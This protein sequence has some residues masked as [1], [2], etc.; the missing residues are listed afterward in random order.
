[1]A[2]EIKTTEVTPESTFIPPRAA[3]NTASIP[4]NIPREAPPAAREG[5]F[6]TDGDEDILGHDGGTKPETK[7]VV[8]TEDKPSKQEDNKLEVKSATA[9]PKQE[10]KVE[11]ESALSILNKTKQPII[12]PNKPA[13]TSARDYTGFTAEEQETLK[14]MSNKAFDY[15]APILRKAKEVVAP[16]AAKQADS[17]AMFFQHPQGY[18]LHPEF[19]KSQQ[20]YTNA[21][22]EAAV[23]QEQLINIKEGK[24][25]TPPTGYDAQGN[26]IYGSKRAA[27]AQDE[28]NVQQSMN[29][30]MG[31]AQQAQLQLQHLPQQFQQIVQND[32]QAVQA[33]RSKRFDWVRNPELLKTELE[34]P[35]VGKKQIGAVRNEFVSLF[36][37]YQ[38][39]T[40]GVEV[41]ADLFVALQIYASR[42]RQLEGSTA[43]AAAVT[44]EKEAV[45]ERPTQRPRGKGKLVH[46]VGEFSLDGMPT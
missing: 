30:C 4:R 25:F 40:P 16:V 17:N 1:M 7:V 21:S 41:G 27:T 5:E 37:A 31:I 8:R 19:Q 14:S 6:N 33:E 9:A 39:G 35:G 20:V 23:W 29:Q 42:I 34:I 10:A 32:L 26:I 11:E 3:A 18:T 13:D 2:D 22:R 15:A 45:E 38:H 36:P 28:L 12:R 24:E 43:I 46:G 44:E